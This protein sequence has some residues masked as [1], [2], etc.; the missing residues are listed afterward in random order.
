MNV[1]SVLFHQDPH[2]RHLNVRD[3]VGRRVSSPEASA[4]EMTFFFNR[5][6]DCN[7]FFFFDIVS[8]AVVFDLDIR[9]VR[10]N[11]N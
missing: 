8:G 4:P 5:S 2:S 9:P 6:I 1:H 7:P 10:P 3:Q 11:K